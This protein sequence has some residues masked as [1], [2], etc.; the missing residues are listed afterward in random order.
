[1]HDVYFGKVLLPI[2]PPSIEI[3]VPGKD[4]TI[5]LINFGEIDISRPAGLMEIPVLVRLPN[6]ELPM[7]RGRHLLPQEFIEYLSDLKKSSTVFQ[8]IVIRKSSRGAAVGDTNISVR[9]MNYKIVEDAADGSDFAVH[10]T[11]REHRKPVIKRAKISGNVATFQAQSGS[12]RWETTGVPLTYVVKKGDTLYN[13]G[14]T[15][16][17]NGEA[18]KQLIDLNNLKNRDDIREGQVLKMPEYYAVGE[19]QTKKDSRW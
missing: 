15:H 3:T 4:E 5:D 17:N 8:F 16:Y 2:S 10:V 6:N 14:R 9:V 13:I 7:S 19:Y 12:N 1:M 18:W 11:L